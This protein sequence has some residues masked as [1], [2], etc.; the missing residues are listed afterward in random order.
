MA[1]S[2]T[3]SVTEANVYWWDMLAGVRIS[4]FREHEFLSGGSVCRRLVC[5]SWRHSKGWVF[6][7]YMLQESLPW[8]GWL[9]QDSFQGSLESVNQRD[10]TNIPTKNEACALVQSKGEIVTFPSLSSRQQASSLPV[11]RARDW[12][13]LVICQG[14]ILCARMWV[15]GG[16]H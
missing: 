1:G 11:F 16:S 15:L 12:R 9:G 13:C 8:A 10:S 6:L 4:G 3:L 5:G 2:L 7:D 14:F